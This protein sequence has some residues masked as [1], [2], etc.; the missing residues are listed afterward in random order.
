MAIILCRCRNTRPDFFFQ[1]PRGF[2]GEKHVPGISPTPFGLPDLSVISDWWL[3]L[4]SWQV[5]P[6]P[7]SDHL[8]FKSKHFSPHASWIS[9]LKSQTTNPWEWKNPFS[10][11]KMN[12]S[13]LTNHE[14]FLGKLCD[15]KKYQT[16]LHFL[17]HLKKRWEIR[18]KTAFRSQSLVAKNNH[19][20]ESFPNHYHHNML[21]HKELN[22]TFN[23][24]TIIQEQVVTMTW[25]IHKSTPM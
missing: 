8:M 7:I 2:Q 23:I 12:E 15:V 18:I 16:N 5:E 13:S 3:I 9:T 10:W 11:W 17:S 19:V 22:H 6:Q 20:L 25:K 1:T 24:H 4:R 14:R 21:V